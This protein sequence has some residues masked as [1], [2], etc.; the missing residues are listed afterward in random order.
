MKALVS[1]IACNPYLG[2]ENFFGWAA[3]KCLSREHDLWVITSTRNR[4]DLERAQRENLIP[5]NVRFA[6]AGAVEEWHLNAL[7]AR[8]QSWRE[9]INFSKASLTVAQDL[10]RNERFDVVHHVTFSTWRVPS[11]MWRLG[12]PFVLGPIAGNEPFPFRLFGVLSWV[13]AAFESVRK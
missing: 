12:I 4:P 7:R 10:H 5:P 9:Y 6:Y 3:V 1:A 13:G 8:I 11:P 2:S